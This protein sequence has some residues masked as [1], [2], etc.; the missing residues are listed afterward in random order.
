MAKDQASADSDVDLPKLTSSTR[1]RSNSRPATAGFP[2][3]G[4]KAG[5]AQA[6]APA[7]AKARQG[8]GQGQR[9]GHRRHRRGVAAEIIR[10]C[11]E[12]N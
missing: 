4:A 5:Q 8:A 9:T 12:G 1:A 7:L 6:P 11:L 2:P 3:S 10:A